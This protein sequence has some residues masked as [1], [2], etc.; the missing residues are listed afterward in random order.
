MKT[1]C[2]IV[3][4]EPLAI[5]V[6][7]THLKNFS[8]LVIAGSC[9]NA[10]EAF[11]FIKKNKID[12]VFL[13]IQMPEI[14]GLSFV[15]SLKH[16]PKI[17]FT[18][19]Y[20]DYAIDGFDLNVLDYLLKPISLE[21]FI[22]AIDKYYA[23]F[24]V[25]STNTPDILF[26]SESTRPSIFVKTERKMVRIFLDEIYFIESLKEY[27]IIYTKDKKVITKTAISF[28]ESTLPGEQFVRIHRSYIVAV[29]KISAYTPTSVEVLN[30]E[31]PIG[32]N[33]KLEA[34]KQLT[35]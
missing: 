14:N 2:L 29:Q 34:L 12:L 16:P 4:D 7:A 26:T 31:M 27:V 35:K 1:Q 28:L 8:E 18:T 6:I 17:I 24:P 10:V 32:R 25:A 23:S 13:D 22:Q 21:R 20:R 3:D 11:E 9:R 33:Y 30:K 5:E 19:A 15:K